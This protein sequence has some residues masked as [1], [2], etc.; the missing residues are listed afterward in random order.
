M[1]VLSSLSR[2]CDTFLGSNKISANCVI[3]FDI[4]RLNYLEGGR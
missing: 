2:Y 4:A 1:E 3:F